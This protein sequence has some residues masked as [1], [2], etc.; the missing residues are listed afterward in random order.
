MPNY[1]SLLYSYAAAHQKT[2]AANALGHKV[3][4]SVCFHRQGGQVSG[5]FIEH[6]TDQMNLTDTIAVRLGIALLFGNH[7]E[8]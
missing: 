7:I 5:V 2:P 8:S 4:L 3:S 6:R 1:D